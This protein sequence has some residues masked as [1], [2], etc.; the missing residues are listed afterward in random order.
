[1]AIGTYLQI[2][3]QKLYNAMTKALIVLSALLTGFGARAES[4]KPAWTK[5]QAALYTLGYD[6]ASD[7]W[8]SVVTADIDYL[9]THPS[10]SYK[11]GETPETP[12]TKRPKIPF[13]QLNCTKSK[14][15]LAMLKKQ[16]A[17]LAKLATKQHNLWQQ[18]DVLSAQAKTENPYAGFASPIPKERLD[19]WT[20]TTNYATLLS[21][22]NARSALAYADSPRRGVL[23][24]CD[25]IAVG[26]AL[27]GS[28]ATLI[29]RIIGV[30]L[31]ST[32]LRLLDEMLVDSK[33]KLPKACQTLLKPLP[34]ERLFLCHS[35]EELVMML[36][37]LKN[38]PEMSKLQ[39]AKTGA[40]GKLTASAIWNVEAAQ[41]MAKKQWQRH[42]CGE[43]LLQSVQN[44][45]PEHPLN[46]MEFGML[47]CAQNVIYCKVLS[48]LMPVSDYIGYQYRLQDANAYLRLWQAAIAADAACEL[49]EKAWNK[50]RRLTFYNTGKVGIRFY[51][52]RI[53]D[54]G[55]VDC[56][57]RLE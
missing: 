52:K 21:G 29:N 15:C 8:D 23:Q 37:T 53:H 24:T 3:G 42:L 13:K 57:L 33:A 2:T 46:E 34:T 32:Q 54:Q 50:A 48:Q 36:N 49:D 7:D 51:S 27:M 56:P 22:L 4:P 10:S 16:Q 5:S 39:D 18:L 19:F 14:N 20:L 43:D 26:K 35:D 55:A 44:D 30:H 9:Q 1:M 6:I 28:R 12:I 47:E 38:V 17:E 45:N 31:V 41:G 11:E 40:L 25:N